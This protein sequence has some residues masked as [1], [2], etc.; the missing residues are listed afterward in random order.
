MFLRWKRRLLSPDWTQ[1]RSR[2]AHQGARHR[3][4][5]V[6]LVSYKDSHGR[7]RH[8]TIWHPGVGIND[9]CLTGAVAK[10]AFWEDIEKRIKALLSP[11]LNTSAAGILI[12]RLDWLRATL[13]RRVAPMT[14]A[15]LVELLEQ[16][17]RGA[18]T[19]D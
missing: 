13:A 5:P 18:R 17:M 4:T 10:H 8:K 19:P 16:Q 7:A 2:C 1:S 14:D 6:V 3:L 9:C 11:P 15:D 12:D